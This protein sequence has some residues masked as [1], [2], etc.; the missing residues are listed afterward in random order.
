MFT[1]SSQSHLPSNLV[2]LQPT[3]AP[4]QPHHHSDHAS[5]HHSLVQLLL[6]AAAFAKH[7]ELQAHI[8]HFNFTGPAFLPVHKLLQQ[9]YEL[10]QEQFDA[11]G[12]FIRTNGAF[13]PLT[14][15]ALYT[16]CDCFCELSSGD[17]TDMLDTYC[18]NLAT[19]ASQALQL[20]SCAAE[21]CAIDVENYAAELVA[22]S[23]KTC[24]LLD[25]TNF[26]S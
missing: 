25:S 14:A 10:H 23:R 3:Q 21:C 20:A 4:Q 2:A 6:K 22:H 17:P 24:Y 5:T 15:Q 19:Q 13:M 8:I 9:Q 7:L 11:L 1:H 16:A 12:E 26:R 18:S